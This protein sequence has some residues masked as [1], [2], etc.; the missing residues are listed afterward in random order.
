MGLL[1][2]KVEVLSNK[3]GFVQVLLGCFEKCDVCMNVDISIDLFFFMD[4]GVLKG[5]VICIGFD[6]LGLDFQKQWDELIFLVIVQLDE[7][8]LCFKSGVLLFLQVGMSLM[9]NIKLCKVFYFQFLLG[10]F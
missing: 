6:V 3:I 8:Q 1:E 2:V 9:V 4:F 5:K 7:Q 10:E